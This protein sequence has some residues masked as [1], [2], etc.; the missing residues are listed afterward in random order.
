MGRY[1]VRVVTGAWL[2]SGSLNRVGLWL[3]G[4]HR[5][6]KLE[7]QLRPARGKVSG[8]CPDWAWEVGKGQ[9]NRGCFSTTAME[10]GGG[11]TR[12]VRSI[13]GLGWSPFPD[14]GPGSP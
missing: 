8:L 3:V 5:E 6:A 4:A 10:F 12:G 9:E 11:G 7:L 14:P 1:R 13:T 2:F